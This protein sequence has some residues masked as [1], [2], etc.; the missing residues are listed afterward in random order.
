M[1]ETVR[2]E[3]PISARFL[4]HTPSGEGTVGTSAIVISARDEGKAFTIVHTL[5]ANTDTVYIGGSG[6]T[7][8]LGVPLVADRF[9]TIPG[10][11]AVYAIAGAASQGYR[12]ITGTK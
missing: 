10:S 8:G 4:G 9:I 11:A 1:S 5:A 7:T 12:I 3:D 2:M 6:V